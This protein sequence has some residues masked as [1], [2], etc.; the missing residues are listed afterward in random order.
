MKVIKREWLAHI[1]RWHLIDVWAGQLCYLL[2][3]NLLLVDE[4]LVTSCPA[5]KEKEKKKANLEPEKAVKEG[6]KMKKVQ[7]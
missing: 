4:K 7:I 3:F 1:Y 2:R 6:K 5:A